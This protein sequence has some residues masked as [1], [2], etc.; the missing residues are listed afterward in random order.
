[1]PF[2][3]E[4]SFHQFSDLPFLFGTICLCSWKFLIWNLL[5]GNEMTNKKTSCVCGGWSAMKSPEVDEWLPSSSSSQQ[6][7][8]ESVA[9]QDRY[10]VP[11]WIDLWNPWNPI[12]IPQFWGWFHTIFVG[13]PIFFEP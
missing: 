9:R 11:R 2:W 12:R 5:W 6:I 13:G 7:A 3:W 1:L 4:G 8:V 10:S